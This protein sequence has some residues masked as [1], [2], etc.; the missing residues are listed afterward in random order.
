MHHEKPGGNAGF[1]GLKGLYRSTIV[2]SASEASLLTTTGPSHRPMDETRFS[3]QRFFGAG[4]AVSVLLHALA[5]LV[6]IGGVVLD[7][8][9]PEQQ[10][11]DVELVPP[12]EPLAPE[13]PPEQQELELPEPEIPEPEVSELEEQAPPPEPTPPLEEQPE[14]EQEVAELPPLVPVL[15]PVVEFG[16]T[17]SGPR[18]DLD[19]DSSEAPD[20]PEQPEEDVDAAE[21]TEVEDT[22]PES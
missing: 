11:I 7:V 22:E 17:D 13:P 6:L 21:D 16:E 2:T 3:G 14:P 1:F 19:G 18:V 8:P 9:E 12:P 15:Q 5:G 20:D 4:L 10:S